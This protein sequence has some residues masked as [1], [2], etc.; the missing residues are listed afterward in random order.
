MIRAR[1]RI[2]LQEGL[3]VRD[4]SEVFPH[5]TFKLLS[6]YHSGETAIELGEIVADDPGAC[7]EALRAHPGIAA[8]ELL[9]SGDRRALSKYETTHTGLYEF[10]QHSELPVEFPVVAKNG[11]FEFDLTGTRAELD[12]LQAVLEQRGSEY[13]LLSVVS[14]GEGDGLVTERQ[15]ELLEAAIREG[16]YEVPRECTLAELAESVGVDKSTASTVLRRGEATVLKSFLSGSE[17]G[18]P[19]DR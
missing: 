6:G 5:A 14:T 2:R 7:V 18:P 9:E 17:T 4:L 12:R 16:Y 13:E 8:F 10:V 3:W 1:L 11:W 15:R 19:V